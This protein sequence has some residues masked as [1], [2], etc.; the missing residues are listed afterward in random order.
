MS[1]QV[2]KKRVLQTEVVVTFL[3][4][5]LTALT[6]SEVR[7]HGFV[8]YDDGLYVYEN[9][10]VLQGLTW[11][12]IA[13][14][15]TRLHLGFWFPLTWLSFMLDFEIFGLKLVGYHVTNVLLHTSNTVLLF[16]IL[17]RMTGAVWRSAFVA[18]LFAFHPLRVES[19]AWVT[20]CK[21][22]LSTFFWILTLVAY[23]YY[24]Q[25]PRTHRYL[26]VILCFASALMAKPM[27]VTGPFV[28]LLLDY[29]PLRRFS[30]GKELQFDADEVKLKAL[31]GA[32]LTQLIV[33]K[34]PLVL[35]SIAISV[36]TLLGQKRTGS[37]VSLEDFPTDIRLANA[38]VSYVR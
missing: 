16:F 22:M 35:L 34:I 25:V 31:P 3:L 29:W 33:E 6:F 2:I 28:L 20:E 12:S 15:F 11:N 14:A 32:S 38:L 21:D 26:L 37:L 7:S 5:L 19:V 10:L 1:K 13:E 8:D 36:V 17:R 9:R 24:V 27:L 4:I 18:A 30:S 23:F